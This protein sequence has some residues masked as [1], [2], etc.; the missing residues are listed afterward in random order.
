MKKLAYS[1]LAAGSLALC[2]G[3]T[4]A[5][6]SSYTIKPGDTLWKVAS[7]NNVS[8]ANIK[9]WNNLKSDSI[10]PNQVLKL[11][12]TAPSKTPASTTTATPS[13]TGASSQNLY[14]VK[15]GDTLYKIASLHKT[16]VSNIQKLNNLS[17]N[18]ISVGQKL[19]VSGSVAAPAAPKAPAPAKTTAPAV[20]G[21]TYKVVSGDTLTNIAHRHGIAVTQLMNWNGLTSSS[22]RVGQVLNVKNATVVAQPKP[23][24]VSQPAVP[25]AGAAGKV[26]STA[27]SLTGIPYVWGG[28]TPSGFDCSGYIYYVYNKAGVSLPR[29]NTTGYDAR[30]YDVS[31]PKPGDL[32][33]FSNT[34]RA[35]ISHMGIYL[36]DN[37]FI[38][39]GGDRVQITSLSDSYWGKHF[40][41]FKR[42]YA[43]D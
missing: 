2:I 1:V 39:A 42:L 24:P 33:F 15:S 5:D 34:Y 26:I 13:S 12:A 41:G 28:A 10:Y 16:T 19:K 7:S 21:S 25:A 17:K 31:N 3:A 18:T 43:M 8:V 35:G 22:I 32:V 27:T 14:I 6:A 40:D 23:T 38:H 36:G 29:T 20:S 4:S 30:S 11:S 9:Q 37:K